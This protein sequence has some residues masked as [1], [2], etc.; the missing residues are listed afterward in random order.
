MRVSD[1]IPPAVKLSWLVQ[2]RKTCIFIIITLKYSDRRY[3]DAHPYNDDNFYLVSFKL[4]F[5]QDRAVSCLTLHILSLIFAYET[6][7]FFSLED[8]V[9][10]CLSS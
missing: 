6:L 2:R 3:P 10:P 5:K 7:K 1:F 8:D 9:T 4:Y